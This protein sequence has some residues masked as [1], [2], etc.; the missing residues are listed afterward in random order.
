K[1]SCSLTLVVVEQ[2]VFAVGEDPAVAK[3][4]EIREPILEYRNE[5]FGDAGVIQSTPGDFFVLRER[6]KGVCDICPDGV[7]RLVAELFAEKFLDR[8]LVPSL[9]VRCHRD[10]P[11]L[12]SV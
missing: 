4:A 2:E 6:V 1:T 5:V 7:R 11:F 9:N 3:I 8:E 12:G 10:D